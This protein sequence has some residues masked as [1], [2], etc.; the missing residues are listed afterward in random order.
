MQ[1]G[2]CLSPGSLPF[3][4]F[5]LHFLLTYLEYQVDHNY[6]AN[7]FWLIKALETVSYKISAGLDHLTRF[8][9]VQ[10][11]GFEQELS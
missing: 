9:G 7:F 5:Q 11:P 2:R 3:R 6:Y 10:K 8:Q 4:H 1:N